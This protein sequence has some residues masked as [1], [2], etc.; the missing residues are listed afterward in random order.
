MGNKKGGL[1]FGVIVGT[2]LGV[3]FA[4]K[5]GTELRKDLKSEVKKG[6][7]GTETLKKSFMQMGKDIAGTA[8]ELYQQPEVQKHV[9][10]GKKEVKN[11]LKNVGDQLQDVQSEVEKVGKDYYKKGQEKYEEGMEQMGHGIDMIKKRIVPDKTVK[12]KK[13][14]V[15]K[16]AKRTRKVP[17]KKA[18]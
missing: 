14:A 17:I 10:K 11:F 4:P 8:E 9:N 5:K 3:L 1:F 18:K 15:K 12:T 13:R 6:G 7:V 16:P 2:L